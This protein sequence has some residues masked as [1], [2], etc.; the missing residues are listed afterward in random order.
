MSIIRIRNSLLISTAV[1]AFGISTAQGATQGVLEASSTGDIRISLMTA[2][3]IRISNLSD[4]ALTFTPGND[5]TGSSPA[6]IYR[7]GAGGYNL[8]ASGSGTGNAFTLSDGGANILPY[9]VS[10]NDGT[11]RNTLTT[12]IPLSGRTNA[13]TSS[14]DCSGG[15]MNNGV[16]D[17]TIVSTD[18]DA[19]PAGT[20]SG[21]LTLVVS[22]E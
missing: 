1:A 13:N 7:N 3:Q 20:Y 5:S 18:V 22:P 17:V 14:V 9:S 21:V 19:A 16:I 4:I 6:C 8:N 10:F 11:G 12:A 15:A 2:S